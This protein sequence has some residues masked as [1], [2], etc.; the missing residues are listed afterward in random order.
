MRRIVKWAGI[1]LV[2]L[3]L[4]GIGAALAGGGQT[5]EQQAR[6]GAGQQ[7]A[8]RG[9]QHAACQGY[10]VGTP[11]YDRCV[12]VN[13]TTGPG[14]ASQVGEEAA[15]GPELEEPTLAE[16][17]PP[18]PDADGQY[19]LTCDYELGDFG[20]S[21][22]PDQG[23]RFIAGGTI[24]NTGNVWIVVRATYKWRLLGQGSLIERRTYR[25][26][27][28][29]ERDV[30][31]V[32]PVTQDQIDAHQSAGSKCSTDVTIIESFGTPVE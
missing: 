25:L 12:Q 17:P 8:V 27:R 23:Y 7:P 28:G 3:L 21:G 15:N 24:S 10:E 9:A 20:D 19:E 31:V 6:N 16:D 29:Q 1:A 18:E 32:I 13:A 30:D 5:N 11:Q 26:R 14:P 4:V 2:A 22:D